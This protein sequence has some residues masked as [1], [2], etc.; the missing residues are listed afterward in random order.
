MVAAKKLKVCMIQFHA[1]ANKQENL[2]KIQ[3]MIMKACDLYQPDLLCLPEACSFRGKSDEEKIGAETFPVSSNHEIPLG[4]LELNDSN[5]AKAP[6]LKLMSNLAQEFK[7]CIMGGS[8]FEGD[9]NSKPLNTAF[10]LNKE[11]KLVNRYSKIH[12]FDVKIANCPTESNTRAAGSLDIANTQVFRD[13]VAERDLTFAM[14]ICYDLRFPEFFRN[15]MFNGEI[16]CPDIIFLPSA[17]SMATGD[18]HW[19]PL[20]RAR[21]IENTVFM[22]APNQVGASAS[23]FECHGNSMI[24]DP[25]GRI[26][27]R[28]GDWEEVVY[29]EIDVEEVN[30]ARKSLPLDNAR[31]KIISL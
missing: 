28:G 13:K 22:I 3:S 5:C 2:E 7:V 9:G 24:V 21:A 26:I 25:W 12:L 23:G 31:M 18:P 6:S 19:E 14:G 4:G 27:A 8:I 29:A 1:G 16:S 30:K 15:F 20:L 10:Y 11:G 17:F